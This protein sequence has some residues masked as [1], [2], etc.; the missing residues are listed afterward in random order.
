MIIYGYTA[1]GVHARLLPHRRAA[2][3][4]GGLVHPPHR[5]QHLF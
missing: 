1:D 2:A 4:T 3:K 5:L